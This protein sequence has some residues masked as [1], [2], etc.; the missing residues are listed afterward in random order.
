[1]LGYIKISGNYNLVADL[2]SKVLMVGA[3]YLQCDTTAAPVNIQL[4]PISDLAGFLNLQINVLDLAGHASA[5]PITVYP[6]PTDK[7]N[8]QATYIIST[9]GASGGLSI[10]GKNDWLATLQ[11]ILAAFPD[12]LNVTKLIGTNPNTNF[13]PKVTEDNLF[14]LYPG[15]IVA[16]WDTATGTGSMI[17]GADFDLPSGLWTVPKTGIYLSNAT[18][19]WRI[20]TASF[21]KTSN[22]GNSA[23]LPWMT[24]ANDQGSFT[25]GIFSVTGGNQL[26]IASKVLNQK[27]GSLYLQCVLTAY[28]LTAGTQIGL[29]ANNYSDLDMYGQA[30][31]SILWRMIYLGTR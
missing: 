28:Y 4:P 19:G 12:T 1:M 6:D 14:A 26:A 7:I 13:F 20:N 18:I 8:T 16:S 17:G 11:N 30:N 31:S 21:A 2:N 5:H 3:I 15:N 25:M 29:A 10:V 22:N 9:D 27:I 23:G 24:V